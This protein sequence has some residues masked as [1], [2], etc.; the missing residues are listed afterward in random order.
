MAR[1][2]NLDTALRAILLLP[3][4]SSPP[5]VEH[6]HEHE[7]EQEQEKRVSNHTVFPIIAITILIK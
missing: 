4:I 6:E 5:D 3:K 2:G 7:H 1:T